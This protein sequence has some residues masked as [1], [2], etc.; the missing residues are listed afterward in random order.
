MSAKIRVLIA[1]DH[2]IVR[3]G[4]RL[5]LE[6]QADMD[7]V[8]EASDG[9]EAVDRARKLQPDIVLMDISMP[10]MDGLEATRQIR[11]E[12]PNAHVVGLTVHDSDAYFFRMLEAGASGYVLKGAPSADLLAAIR[13]AHNGSVFLHPSLIGRLVGDYLRRVHQGETSDSYNTLSEREKEVLRLLG[14]G[15]TNQE[16]AR[17][18]HLSMSTVQTHRSHIMEKLNLQNRAELIKYALRRGLID[19]AK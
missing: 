5:I 18:L 13:G 12:L 10:G 3:E 14:E 17:R 4:I 1:E 8:G 6:A 9:Q 15:H 19:P 2:T 7:V 16:I 11:R